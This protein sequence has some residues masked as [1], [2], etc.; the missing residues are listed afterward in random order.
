M[1]FAGQ[2]LAHNP[3]PMQASKSKQGSPRYFSGNLGF[4]VGY[5]YV[6]GLENVTFKALLNTAGK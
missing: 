1:A 2:S 5:I 6:A 4:W 3:Q